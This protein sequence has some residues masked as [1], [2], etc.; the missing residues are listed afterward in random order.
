[1]EWTNMGT[2]AP[3]TRGRKRAAD[4]AMGPSMRDVAAGVCVALRRGEP[5]DPQAAQLVVSAA[6]AEGAVGSDMDVLVAACSAGLASMALTPTAARSGLAPVGWAGP[7]AFGMPPSPSPPSPYGQQQ[8][9]Q[10]RQYSPSS[11]VGRKRRADEALGTTSPRS[12][13]DIAVDICR[14]TYRGEPVSP[15]EIEAL[16]EIAREEGSPGAS[17]IRDVPGLCRAALVLMGESPATLTALAGGSMQARRPPMPAAPP[18]SPAYPPMVRL[19]LAPR[20]SRP[21]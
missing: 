18:S 9:Q 13:R 15:A 17:L 14:R 12:A 1:M 16:R 6:R 8:Q 7:A 10:Y 4:V 3:E 21:F 5:V 20:G 19:N 11:A 2:W